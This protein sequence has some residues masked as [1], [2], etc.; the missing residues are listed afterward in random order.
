MRT[1]AC[2]SLNN[3][4]AGR[5]NIK[6]KNSESEEKKTKKKYDNFIRLDQA[7]LPKKIIRLKRNF[8]MC[9]RVCVCKKQF[10]EN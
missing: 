3:R 5:N 10:K 4:D 8:I 2:S 6:I 7:L 9:Y 1:N